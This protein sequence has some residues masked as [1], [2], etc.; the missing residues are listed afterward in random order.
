MKDAEP[1]QRGQEQRSGNG[2]GEGG[3]LAP[4]RLAG[5]VDNH[6]FETVADLNLSGVDSDA[7]AEECDDHGCSGEPLSKGHFFPRSLPPNRQAQGRTKGEAGT[8]IDSTELRR[9]RGPL[10]ALVMESSSSVWGSGTSGKPVAVWP[11][12]RG[13]PRPAWRC[14]SSEDSTAEPSVTELADPNTARSL[15]SQQRSRVP[16]AELL[17]T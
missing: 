11:C 5:H 4:F 13:V 7:R 8:T 12:G 17:S 15:G 6:H 3:N 10:C 1:R 9:P 2:I 14:G 16:H